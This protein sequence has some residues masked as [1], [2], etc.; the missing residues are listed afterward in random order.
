MKKM[1]NK[2]GNVAVIALIVVIVAVNAGV[3]GYMFANK[4]Q[5]S[6]T[7]NQPSEI[8][9]QKPDEQVA[10]TMEAKLC[11]DGS[12]VERGGPN[13]E[14]AAC[15]GVE[16]R[17]YYKN[18]KYGVEFYYPENM[19][20]FLGEPDRDEPMLFVKAPEGQK[21]YYYTFAVDVT[22]LELNTNDTI[23][24]WIKEQKD[25]GRKYEE[26]VI[27]GEKAYHFTYNDVTHYKVLKGNTSYDITIRN[28]DIETGN[29]ILKSFKFLGK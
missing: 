18:E 10:C 25:S 11:P 29:T 23:D 16:A 7:G 24:K 12:Y 26:F 2:K 21:L 13:C 5:S 17:K 15:V 22:D 19:S 28:A 14:F 8:Q 20:V 9:Q 4:K 6:V 3:F 1:K 27:A